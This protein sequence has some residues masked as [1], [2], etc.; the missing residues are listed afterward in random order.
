MRAAFGAALLLGGAKQYRDGRL[1]DSANMPRTDC[2]K[3]QWVRT[4]ST[5]DAARPGASFDY[6]GAQMQVL[7]AVDRNDQAKAIVGTL[8]PWL[9][10]TRVDSQIAS[11]VELAASAGG[12]SSWKPGPPGPEPRERRAAA[13]PSAQVLD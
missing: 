4:F 2:T 3:M 5:F 9:A 10:P 1:G 11:L 6:G 13:E 7:I 12:G 8:T